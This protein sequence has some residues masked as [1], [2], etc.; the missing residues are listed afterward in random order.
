MRRKLDELPVCAKL[1][2]I[3]QSSVAFTY[4]DLVDVIVSA[5]ARM[6]TADALIQLPDRSQV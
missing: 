5:I 3:G 1:R 2:N 4:V 6:S